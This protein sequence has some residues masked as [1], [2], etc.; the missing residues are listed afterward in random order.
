VNRPI[1]FE[2]I[3]AKCITA[4]L[5]S[6]TPYLLGAG[7]ALSLQATKAV[8]AWQSQ[9]LRSNPPHFANTAL[10]SFNPQKGLINLPEETRRR[11][12]IDTKTDALI[13]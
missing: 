12:F 13:A 11:K 6:A 3:Y 2:R 8:Y 1:H 7:I 10:P 4:S 5:A 9:N